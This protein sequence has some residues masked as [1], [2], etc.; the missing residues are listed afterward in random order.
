MLS[1]ARPRY[2]ALATLAILLLLGTQAQ[3]VFL[4]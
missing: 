4:F 1:F 2:L 3:A